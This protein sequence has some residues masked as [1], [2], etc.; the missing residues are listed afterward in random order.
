MIPMGV[1]G[2]AG[3]ERFQDVE[4]LKDWRCGMDSQILGSQRLLHVQELWDAKEWKEWKAVE[5]CGRFWKLS[6]A[7]RLWEVVEDLG[8]CPRLEDAEG[9]GSSGPVEGVCL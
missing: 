8:I 9:C 7:R 2:V 1:G 5:G 3:L 4:G 6:N